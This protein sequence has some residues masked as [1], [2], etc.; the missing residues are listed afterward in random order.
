MGR[1]YSGDIQ[2][3]FWFGVQ[4]SDCADRF[5]VTGYQPEVLEYSF[6]EDN[7]EDINEELS[8]IK[9]YLGDNLYKLDL[10]FREAR[11]YT[12]EELGK[13]L[14]IVKEEEVKKVLSEY[15]DYKMGLEIKECVETNKY[16]DFTA[17]LC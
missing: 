1:Y 4:S 8:K 16:C 11:G 2:G 5:G 14:N 3:K 7:L 10:F 12:F 6:D 9:E 15:A 17:E 13:Y